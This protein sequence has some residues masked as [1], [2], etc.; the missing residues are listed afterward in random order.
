MKSEKK[1]IP[2]INTLKL[3][4]ILIVF[5]SHCSQLYPVSYMATGG[6]R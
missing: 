6:S 1:Q 4:A 2:I 5:N 3:F